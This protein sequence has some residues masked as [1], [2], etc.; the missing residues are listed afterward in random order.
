MNHTKT[1]FFLLS[2]G[3]ITAER[4][5][6]VD[7]LPVS[8]LMLFLETYSLYLCQLFLRYVAALECQNILP[9]S[10]RE[11]A[12][13]SLYE[14][15]QNSSNFEPFCQMS[16]IP[17]TAVLKRIYTHRHCLFRMIRVHLHIPQLYFSPRKKVD[18]SLKDLPRDWEQK[19][20]YISLYFEFLFGCT[21]NLSYG[22][23]LPP[24]DYIKYRKRMI[25]TSV[26]LRSILQHYLDSH[27]NMI[28]KRHV[29]RQNNK[30]CG[31]HNFCLIEDILV[32]LTHKDTA[33]LIRWYISTSSWCCSTCDVDFSISQTQW[34]NPVF[35]ES[36]TNSCVFGNNHSLDSIVLER[37]TSEAW[38]TY[39]RSVK[40]IL[41]GLPLDKDGSSEK[42]VSAVAPCHFESKKDAAQKPAIT[43]IC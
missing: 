33:K 16:Q 3:K 26:P 4:T 9:I 21:I 8:V 2:A 20:V 14:S 42:R 41:G 6:T 11:R 29:T 34:E 5:K 23:E 15:F 1:R 37:S 12:L 28:F 27:A 38:A 32:A 39:I 17:L 36:P 30:W 10:S 31:D 18:V 19:H 43:S 25:S 24:G 40:K 7:R 13:F 22:F 35:G